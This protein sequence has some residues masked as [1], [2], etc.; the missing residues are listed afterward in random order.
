MSAREPIDG[1]GWIDATVPMKSGMAHW[2]GSPPVEVQETESIDRG[3]HC[4]VSVLRFGSHT[5][6]HVDAPGHFLRGGSRVDAMPL[7]GLVGPARVIEVSGGPALGPDELGPHDVARGERIILRTSNTPR[8]WQTDAFVSDYAYLS[9]AGAQHLVARGVRTVGIDYLSI[10]GGDE[11][12]ATHAALL[13]AGVVI[14][15]GLRL[16]EVR[17]GAH[18]MI[19]LPLLVAGGDGAP[20]RVL[21]RRR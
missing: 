5:G 15:E 6:T 4:T 17:A 13:G 11:S 12:A 18:D 9:L 14:I 3:D 19:C 21:L 7:E 2:P 1:A 10:A 16:A 8:C 20:A